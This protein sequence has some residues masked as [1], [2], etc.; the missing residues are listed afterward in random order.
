MVRSST[1]CNFYLEVPSLY[2]SFIPDSKG[3]SAN[4]SYE[5]LY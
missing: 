4:N 3:I 1:Q 2:P 5:K